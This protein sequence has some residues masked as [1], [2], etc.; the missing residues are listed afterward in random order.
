MSADRFETSG[1]FALR[2]PLLPLEAFWNWGA[3]LRAAGVTEEMEAACVRDRRLLQRRLR[4]ILEDAAVREALFV[5]SPS[6]SDRLPVWLDDPDSAKGRGVERALVKY[7]ARMSGRATPFGLF[8]GGS[9]GRVAQ[10]THLEF[11]ERDVYSRHT[12]LDMD[13]L[14]ALVDGLL[15]DPAVRAELSYVPNSTLYRI[16]DRWHYVEW[17]LKG[18]ERSY[19]LVVADDDEYLRA[20]LEAASGGA[21]RSELAGGLV[22]DE[23]TR[24]EAEEYVD[25]LIGSQVLVPT[26]A[27]AVTGPETIDDLVRQLEGY[28]STRPAARTL[29]H[30][31]DTLIEMDILGPGRDPGAYRDVAA[32]L[33]DLPAEAEIS[34]LFQVDLTKPVR[35]LKLG[36]DVLACVSETLAALYRLFGRPS[37]PLEDMKKRFGERYGD[38]TVRLVDALDDETG[39][40]LLSASGP[41]SDVSPLLAGLA[42]PGRAGTGGSSTD[43]SD[44]WLKAQLVRAAREGSEELRF[45]PE[46][47]PALQTGAAAPLPD[48]LSVMGSVLGPGASRQDGDAAP[49]IVFRGASGP[50]GASMLGRFC[51]GDPELLEGAL[52]HL[53]DEEKL[54]PD[55]I[56]AEIVH[57]PEGRIGNVLARP[58]LRDYEI[59]YLGRSGA[60]DER[61]IRID[62]LDLSLQEGRLVL[63]SRSL[64][65]EIRPRLTTAHNTEGRSLGLYRFLARLSHQGLVRGLGW[66]WGSHDSLPFLPRVR[67]GRAVVS[68][69]TWN[70]AQPELKELQDDREHEAFRKVTAWRRDRDLPRFVGL[71]DGDNV[72]PISTLR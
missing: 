39:V 53:R 52:R 45:S 60:A 20:T 30:V 27:T 54:A 63:T 5:A 66:S 24:E 32:S 41:Q 61:Q 59:P 7:F 31:R 4:R 14:N 38:Q 48:A 16:G 17:R 36:E 1:F 72:L 58:L 33:S 43:A 37:D 6:L 44:Q 35:K 50:S 70:A 57:L 29:E 12:R 23:I 55:V 51:H 3:G 22:D 18:R 40:G 28:P 65:K 21:A 49:R 34:R 26:L 19:A 68:P 56:F 15:A 9:V 8:A 64:G 10:E 67:I 42:F 47:L 62:D 2:S 69:R 11:L 13:F 25:E 71:A 46:E